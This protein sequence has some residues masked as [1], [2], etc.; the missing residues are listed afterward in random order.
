[1][2]DQ[3]RMPLLVFSFETGS[4]HEWSAWIDQVMGLSLA[5]IGNF[6]LS[7]QAG[8]HR[9]RSPTQAGEGYKLA[10][11]WSRLPFKGL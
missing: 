5:I 9:Q 6:Q 4:L 8:S 7:D 10:S 11:Y 2:A 3:S 1:M